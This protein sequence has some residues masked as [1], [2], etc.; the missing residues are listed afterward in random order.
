MIE[1]KEGNAC[2]WFCNRHRVSTLLLAADSRQLERCNYDFTN[3][4]FHTHEPRFDEQ[5]GHETQAL[6][7]REDFFFVNGAS[8]GFY[9]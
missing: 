8:I 3:Y 6:K 7:Q 9:T 1:E 5:M 4:D 2:I